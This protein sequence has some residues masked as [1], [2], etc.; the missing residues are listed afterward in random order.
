ML[1]FG[2]SYLQVVKNFIYRFLV[3][4]NATILLKEHIIL[5]GNDNTNLWSIVEPYLIVTYT[6]TKPIYSLENYA[7]VIFYTDIFIY[8]FLLFLHQNL[9]K[10]YFL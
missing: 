1:K 5:Y 10:F 7:V 8:N 3:L 6:F 2:Q 4:I 9:Q